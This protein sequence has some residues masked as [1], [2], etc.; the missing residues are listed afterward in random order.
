MN[1][2]AD[3]D[4]LK[5]DPSFVGQKWEKITFETKRRTSPLDALLISRKAI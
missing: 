4:M 3:P 2:V 5:P 1:R